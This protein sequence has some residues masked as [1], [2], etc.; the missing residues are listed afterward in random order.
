MNGPKDSFEEFFHQ[1][2]KDSEVVNQAGD[3]NLPSDAVWEGI[4]EGMAEERKLS[5][6]FL[7]WPWSA[8]AA[9]YL[10]IMGGYQ[11]IEQYTEENDLATLAITEV[12][13][14]D[15][16]FQNE[17]VLR[18]DEF[19]H[20]ENI[21][22]EKI[23]KRIVQNLNENWNVQAINSLDISKLHSESLDFQKSDLPFSAN[24]NTVQSI[25]NQLIIKRKVPSK[26]LNKE[27]VERLT[28]ANF[29]KLVSLDA[30]RQKLP[31][32]PITPMVKKSSNLYLSAN[33]STISETLKPSDLIFPL[34]LVSD[35]TEL[36]KGNSVGLDIGWTNK[37]GLGIETGIHY[38][39][40]TKETNINQ[41]IPTPL[42]D[43]DLTLDESIPLTLGWSDAYGSKE[44]IFQLQ[45]DLNNS[46][47]NLT[48]ANIQIKQWTQSRFIEIPLLMRK[49][50]TIGKWSVSAKTGLL[51]RFNISNTFEAPTVTL[52]EAELDLVTNEFRPK[53]G[54]QN[55]KYIPQLIAGIGVEYF[56]QPNL[57]VYVEPTFSRS[58]RPVID[59]SFANIHSQNKAVTMGMRYHL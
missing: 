8:I 57:S 22:E 28:T 48:A 19:I 39:H 55:N 18:A 51:N 27:I 58:L 26:L 46:T 49:D 43:T 9:S 10:L 3:W 53:V 21:K 1:S 35:K 24:E 14:S 32:P 50:W 5:F 17:N 11:F 41:L 16:N 30:K 38:T 4:Q 15:D 13:V 33:Y 54:I 37:K 29:P 6:A 40:L 56:I 7:K 25:G 59:F 31:L 2:Y 45:N 20:P 44:L 34:P 12:L 42:N 36:A 52:E 47:A 23:E